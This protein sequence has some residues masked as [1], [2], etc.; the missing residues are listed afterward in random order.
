MAQFEHAHG[1]GLIIASSP[2]LA[3]LMHYLFLLLKGIY[4]YSIRFCSTS[5]ASEV[6]TNSAEPLSVWPAL[7]YKGS[8]ASQYICNIARLQDQ[9][10]NTTIFPQAERL[11]C[12]R[13]TLSTLDCLSKFNIPHSIGGC[14]S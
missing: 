6:R 3:V 11:G 8:I 12:I 13:K 9:C 10:E 4:I 14:D 5:T 1:T 2:G 7:W